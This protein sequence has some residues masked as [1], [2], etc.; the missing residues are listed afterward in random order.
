MKEVDLI[1]FIRQKRIAAFACSFQLTQY[2]AYF[3]NKFRKFCMTE[4]DERS[5]ETNKALRGDLPNCIG[6]DPED[7]AEDLLEEM[8]DKLDLQGNEIDRRIREEIL[9]KTELAGRM[10]IPGFM[11]RPNTEEIDVNK[12]NELLQKDDM[13]E[14]FIE[15]NINATYRDSNEINT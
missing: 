4:I 13:E 8:S 9:L 10:S 6:Y 3:I 14:P 11:A 2:Q 5:E 1:E 15:D 7:Y 12:A